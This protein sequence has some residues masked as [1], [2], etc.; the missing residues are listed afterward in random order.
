MPLP[1]PLCEGVGVIRTPR[2]SRV[3]LLSAWRHLGFVVAPFVHSEDSP[4]LWVL[5]GLTRSAGELQSP[6]RGQMCTSLVSPPPCHS[7]DTSSNRRS[8]SCVCLHVFESLFF[9][10]GKG[11]RKRGKHNVQEKHP[12]V[13]SRT[14]P[15]GDP[16]C[17]LTGNPGGDLSVGRSALS[18]LSHTSQG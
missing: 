18:P 7:C 2:G 3:G 5:R 4:A 14:S 15:T 16:A 10:E 12:S 8:S 6:F 13:A 11:G 9:L 1:G 17:A